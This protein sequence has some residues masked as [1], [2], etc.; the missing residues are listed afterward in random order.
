MIPIRVC[1]LRKDKA[2]P[3][4]VLQCELDQF[5]PILVSVKVK[6]GWKFVDYFP[7]S[8]NTRARDLIMKLDLSEF[9]NSDHVQ[10][11]LQTTFMFWDLDYAGMDFSQGNSYQ[12]SVIPACKE[13]KEQP[14]TGVVG[15][16]SN[17]QSTLE[18]KDG[19]K[20]KSGI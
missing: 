13:F 8:G 6:S 19:E 1:Y 15:Q 11:R 9:S 12:V 2:D 18:I 10:I 3:E 17:D 16:F 14:G 7:T 4:K 5:L 20:L